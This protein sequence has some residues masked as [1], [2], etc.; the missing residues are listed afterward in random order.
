MPTRMECYALVDVAENFIK[1][2]NTFDGIDKE[3][4]VGNWR[5]NIPYE[6]YVGG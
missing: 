4:I 5:I 6:K 2:D 1:G 3:N